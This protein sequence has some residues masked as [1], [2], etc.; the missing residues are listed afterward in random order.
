MC[1]PQLGAYW[2]EIGLSSTDGVSAAELSEGLAV[3]ADHL[4]AWSS[5]RADSSPISMANERLLAKLDLVHLAQ[6][7]DS[8]VKPGASLG[9][10]T[11]GESS[12]WC[13]LNPGSC[14]TYNTVS[15]GA[16]SSVVAI[17]SECYDKN[18]QFSTTPTGGAAVISGNNGSSPWYAPTTAFADPKRP[19][20]T[21]TDNAGVTYMN[22]SAPVH[23]GSSTAG[24][25]PGGPNSLPK[26]RGVDSTS[27]NP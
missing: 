22:G 12:G 13:N 1:Q 7:L 26:K 15:N 5:G 10:T 11:Y 21:R 8:A 20:C 14:V 4:E 2:K 27:H 23:P 6:S 3:L 16:P 25:Y 18:T 9:L 24:S 19:G 17:P